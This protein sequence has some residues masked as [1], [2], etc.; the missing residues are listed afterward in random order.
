ML[1]EKTMDR[2]ICIGMIVGLFMLVGFSVWWCD[3]HDAPM[4]WEQE[5]DEKGGTITI[6]QAEDT[7]YPYVINVPK[8][9]D[10]KWEGNFL[11][12]SNIKSSIHFTNSENIVVNMNNILFVDIADA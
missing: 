2:C 10:V 5:L 6:I 1:G 9:A 4:T 7:G 12:I 11:R 3:S 8:E